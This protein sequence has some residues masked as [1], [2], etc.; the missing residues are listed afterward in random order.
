M[1]AAKSVNVR[2]N[3]REWCGKVAT[4]ETVVISRPRNE[5][6]Y[7]ISEKEYNELQ[8]AKQ[9]LQYLAKL[10][11]SRANHQ[12]GDTIT[13]SLDELKAMEQEDWL[14]SEK[15]KAFNESHAIEQLP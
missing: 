3:F 5:N 10:D 11:T 12:A 2:N 9:N 14:P 15:V 13:L 4:G 1:L 8:K 7:M 6:I